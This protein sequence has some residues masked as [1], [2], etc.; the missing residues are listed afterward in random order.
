MDDKDMGWQEAM[1]ISL[2]KRK[3]LFEELLEN[4]REKEEK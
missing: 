4:C 2:K 1:H 3:F